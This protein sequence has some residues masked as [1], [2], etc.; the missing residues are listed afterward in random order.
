MHGLDLF[1]EQSI[2]RYYSLAI[3]NNHKAKGDADT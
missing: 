2:G 3:R 1:S